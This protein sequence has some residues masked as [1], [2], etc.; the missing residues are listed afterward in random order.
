M[1]ENQSGGIEKFLSDTITNYA[2]SANVQKYLDRRN[3]LK[4]INH[5]ESLQKNNNGEHKGEYESTAAAK[6]VS[7]NDIPQLQQDMIQR[8]INHSKT[9]D[10]ILASNS[11]KNNYP[12]IEA[13]DY[14]LIVKT[15]EY[16]DDD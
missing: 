5:T 9:T 7:A 11:S 12:T 13:H 3:F 14:D 16:S 2:T 15:P 8:M 1:I 10:Q 6:P 4:R